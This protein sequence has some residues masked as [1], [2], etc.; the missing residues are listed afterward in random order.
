MQE[1]THRS[2]GLHGRVRRKPG[3]RAPRS[4]GGTDSWRDWP[5]VRGGK[6]GEEF[7]LA[8]QEGRGVL[9]IKSW[10]TAEYGG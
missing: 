4:P 3:N 5:R 10:G 6:D 2:A 9:N 8:E 1:E 7:A